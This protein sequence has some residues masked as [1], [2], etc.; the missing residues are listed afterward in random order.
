METISSIN[1]FFSLIA[2]QML[3]K[4]IDQPFSL[5]ITKLRGFFHKE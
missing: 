4:V 3:I 2:E 5:E 1:I